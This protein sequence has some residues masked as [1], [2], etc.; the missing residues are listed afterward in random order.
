MRFM[1]G[2]GGARS[3]EKARLYLALEP[4]KMHHP[5]GQ[6]IPTQRL[7]PER[8]LHRVQDRRRRKVRDRCGW[9]E[10]GGLGGEVWEKGKGRRGRMG[11]QR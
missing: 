6:D 9:V 3:I 10:E 2:L 11:A 5:Q 4:G 1:N 7:Q 8:P